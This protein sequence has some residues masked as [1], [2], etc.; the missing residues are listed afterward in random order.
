MLLKILK[1]LKKHIIGHKCPLDI[2]KVHENFQKMHKSHCF[3][4]APF[5]VRHFQNQESTVFN[6]MQKPPKTKLL[7]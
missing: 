4:F 3:T 2:F 5:M 6:S 7:W 1:I